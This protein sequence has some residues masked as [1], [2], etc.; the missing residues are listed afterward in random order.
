MLRSLLDTVNFFG[1]VELEELL[2]NYS[3]KG[4]KKRDKKELKAKEKKP[5]KVGISCHR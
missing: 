3:E 4:K 2:M 1:I 5:I